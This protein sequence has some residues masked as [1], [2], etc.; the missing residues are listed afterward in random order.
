MMDFTCRLLKAPLTLVTGGELSNVHPHDDDHQYLTC[1]ATW[2]RF[3]QQHGLELRMRRRRTVLGGSVGLCPQLLLTEEGTACS[4]PVRE[5]MTPL[6]II[7][8]NDIH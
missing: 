1:E 8:T 5:Q 7:R 2:L 6:L 3:F 4:G